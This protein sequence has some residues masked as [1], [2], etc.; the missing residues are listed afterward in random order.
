MDSPTRQLRRSHTSLPNLLLPGLVV[1]LGA[2]ITP[3]HTTPNPNPQP[4]Q[5]NTRALPPWYGLRGWTRLDQIEGWMKSSGPVKNPAWV[6][7][8]R[9]ALA[10]GLMDIEPGA[11][12]H[13]QSK[14]R[15]RAH[16]LYA[17]VLKTPEATKDEKTHASYGLRRANGNR[18]PRSP[19]NAMLRN[20]LPR[21]TWSARPVQPSKLTPATGPW[22]WITVHH[23]ALSASD[24]T[25]QAQAARDVRTV[26]NGHM[27]EGRGYGDVGYHFLIDAGGRV[28]Q[29]RELRWQGAHAGGSNNEGNIGICLL[30]NFDKV[31]PT[32]AALSALDRL[33][34]DLHRV[35][36]VR[37]GRVVGHKHWRSTKC[38]G[39][40]LEDHVARLR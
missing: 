6:N 23:S 2:C 37:L 18:V 39:K 21:S 12:D 3:T 20:V 22:E 35:A 31:R 5:I 10:D 26:Q 11:G 19:A 30:G 16:D 36:K 1:L 4:D 15:S 13:L 33:I 40:Y 17:A 32:Q 25:A 28:W 7:Q 24:G 14:R 27:E 29:G 9:L 38:P 34:S 8:A